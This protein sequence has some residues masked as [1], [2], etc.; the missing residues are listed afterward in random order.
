MKNDGWAVLL[1]GISNSNSNDINSFIYPV[2]YYYAIQ[3]YSCMISL[4]WYLILNHIN[5]TYDLFTTISYL[6]KT[7]FSLQISEWL[8]LNYIA[9][10]LSLLIFSSIIPL[11]YQWLIYHDFSCAMHVSTIYISVSM[12]NFGFHIF[13]SVFILMMTSKWMP[14]H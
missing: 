1:Y 11:I 10:N 7:T 2:L 13:V 14:K 8:I 9:S 5:W 4:Y 3:L 6:I 12:A